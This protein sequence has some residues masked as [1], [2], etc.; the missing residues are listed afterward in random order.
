MTHSHACVWLDHQHARIFSIGLLSAEVDIV[1]DHDKVHHIHRKADHVGMGSGPAHPDF[2]REVA[3]ALKGARA[4]LVCGPGETRKELAG[5]LNEHFPAIA[6]RVWGIEPMDHPT[7]AQIIAAARK[8]FHR[9][10][11]MHA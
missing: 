5:Y 11:R 3:Q 2:L 4:I 9:A 1:T 7:D 8:F 10:N 6:K